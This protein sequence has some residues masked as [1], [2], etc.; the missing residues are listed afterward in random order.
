MWIY[1]IHT[2][3]Y[4]HTPSHSTDVQMSIAQ[5]SICQNRHLHICPYSFSFIYINPL[6]LFVPV[7]IYTCALLLDILSWILISIYTEMSISTYVV[8][9]SYKNRIKMPYLYNIAL[10]LSHAF[11]R[12]DDTSLHI[13]FIRNLNFVSLSIIINSIHFW[14]AAV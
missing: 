13:F 10:L 3:T 8:P 9:L 2:C 5:K 12:N 7:W 14:L 1:E 4:L 6:H 11:I